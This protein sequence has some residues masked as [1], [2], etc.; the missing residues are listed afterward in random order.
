LIAAAEKDG[1][2][3]VSVQYDDPDS[4]YR[5][6]LAAD[7]FDWG[8]ANFATV[9]ASTLGVPATV[10]VTVKNCS[11]DDETDGLL[12]LNVDLTDKKRKALFRSSTVQGQ[13]LQLLPPSV[14]KMRANRPV[15][16]ETSISTVHTR[17]KKKRSHGDANASRDVHGRWGARVNTRATAQ[18]DPTPPASSAR[19]R[20][21]IILVAVVILLIVVGRHRRTAQPPS[22]PGFYEEQADHQPPMPTA[23]GKNARRTNFNRRRACANGRF[24]GLS[25]KPQSAARIFY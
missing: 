21:F 5:F 7:L 17:L 14:A 11:F 19:T 12:T 1:V 9:D 10:D 23:A 2:T 8:F 18:E 25:R 15:K 6:K 20:E 16:R 3:L 13:S 24:K 22:V 4:N